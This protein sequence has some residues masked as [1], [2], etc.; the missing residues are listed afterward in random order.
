[1]PVAR[2][3][4]AKNVYSVHPN[5]ALMENWIAT[6]PEKTGRSLEQWVRL[7]K[8]D[9]PPTEA[10]RRAWLKTEHRFGTNAAWSIAER[11]EGRGD[12]EDSAESYLAQAPKYVEAMYAGA[13]SGLRPLHDRLV[14]LGLRLGKD[15]K[16]CPCKTIVPMFRKHVFAQIKPATRTRIDFGLALGDTKVKGRL[17]DT[18]G[19]AKK[20]R[21]THRIPISSLDDIDGEVERWLTIAYDRDA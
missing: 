9:G 12:E 20:D 11:A 8:K 3:A 7:V 1:M 14:D 19:F 6:L 13:K 4:A 15:V 21:I 16:I 10:E 2:K 18:G 17:L 5:V